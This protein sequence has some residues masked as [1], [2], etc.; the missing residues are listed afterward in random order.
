MLKDEDPEMREMGQEEFKDAKKSI[1]I[2]ADELQVLLLPKDPN[3]DRNCYVEIRAGAGCDEAA[4][5]NKLALLFLSA[6]NFNNICS[7]ICLIA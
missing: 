7:M 3:N 4:I 2:L 5:S 6:S 1:V